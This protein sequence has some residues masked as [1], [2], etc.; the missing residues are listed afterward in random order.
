MLDRYGERNLWGFLRVLFFSVKIYQY[1]CKHLRSISFIFCFCWYLKCKW[2]KFSQPLSWINNNLFC[3]VF[4]RNVHR[5]INE[6]DFE[7]TNIKT[8]VFSLT[9]YWNTWPPH[10][11]FSDTHILKTTSHTQY[12]LGQFIKRGKTRGHTL[13]K[14]VNLKYLQLCSFIKQ[15]AVFYVSVSILIKKKI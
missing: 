3:Y 8:I 9:T 2:L 12:F 13:V 11:I 10:A 5:F 6:I 4:S 7:W 1:H 14:Y 15:Y